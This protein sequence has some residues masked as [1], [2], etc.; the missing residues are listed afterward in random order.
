[1]A[2]M[3]VGC[4]DNELKFEGLSVAYKRALWAVIAINGTMFLGEMV[5]IT[6][7][8]TRL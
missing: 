4:C 1:M 2:V 5:A 7:Q 3:S 6:A 8:S